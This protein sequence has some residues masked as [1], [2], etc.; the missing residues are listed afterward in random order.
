MEKISAMLVMLAAVVHAANGQP[1]PN[2]TVVKG[3]AFEGDM[4]APPK[5]KCF[6]GHPLYLDAN[7]S[8]ETWLLPRS[9]A[10]HELV[11]RSMH[12]LDIDTKTIHTTPPASS[13]SGST[14]PCGC[15][16]TPA[17]QAGSRRQ[18]KRTPIS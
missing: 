16:R 14:L 10:H 6:A 8:I 17:T 2:C 3:T 18:N 9:T 13:H 4:P 11:E 1:Q 5:P 12:F 7:G 15:T